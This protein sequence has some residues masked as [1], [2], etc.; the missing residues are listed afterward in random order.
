MP[1]LALMAG[2]PG[3][4]KTTLAL[5]VGRA[6][7]WPVIDKD[8]LKSALLESGIAESLAGRAS[9]QLLHDVGR[10][11]VVRQG[12][13]VI[14]DSPAAYAIVI[15]RA[16]AIAAEVGAH[17]RVVLCLADRDVRNRRMAAR[18]TRPS[19]WN[20]DLGLV[21]DRWEDWSDHLPADTLVVRTDRPPAEL[22]P[23]VVAYLMSR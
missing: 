11:L 6:L 16:A 22:V 7:G 21:G 15:E 2:P 5:A 18:E 17:L 13:S 20:A 23:A 1:T 8:T 4:G 14:L 10:D 9:Y 3:A 12:M 19:Q